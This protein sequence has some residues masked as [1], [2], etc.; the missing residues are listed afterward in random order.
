MYIFTIMNLVDSFPFV[1]IQGFHVC[2]WLKPE[3]PHDHGCSRRS[4]YSITLT[5]SDSPDHLNGQ[6]H[7][8]T[9]EILYISY[10]AYKIYHISHMSHYIIHI[11][12]P[13]HEISESVSE[14]VSG[15]LGLQSISCQRLGEASHQTLL[16]ASSA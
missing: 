2:K 9:Y 10:E 3:E 5:T 12:Y 15:E 1:R 13:S 16:H 4:C 6:S 7:F 11:R 14:S 8:R